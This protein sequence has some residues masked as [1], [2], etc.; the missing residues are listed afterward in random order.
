ML[1]DEFGVHE[2]AQL[3]AYCEL[4]RIILI[5]LIAHS[6]H[7]AS[8][9][10]AGV[11]QPL[12]RAHQMYLFDQVINGIMTVDGTDFPDN[13]V[14][15]NMRRFSHGNIVEVREKMALWPL[16][17]N[18]LLDS[19]CAGSFIVARSLCG[20]TRE[21]DSPGDMTSFPEQ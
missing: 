16:N 19:F 2:R 18:K 12:I 9:L 20:H 11:Y 5:G 6:S 1:C 15:I 13:F 14:E 17:S 10:D 3:V 7:Y 21:D 4:F 8:P